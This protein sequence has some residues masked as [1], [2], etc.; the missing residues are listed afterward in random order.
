M[1]VFPEIRF[2]YPWLLLNTIDFAL[3]PALEKENA[4]D[5]LD[6]EFILER[7]ARH[8]AA[9][10]PYEHEVLKGMCDIFG[11][12][13][14]QNII[15]IYVAPLRHAFSDP[16]MISTKHSPDEVVNVIAHELMHRLLT[17]N[18]LYED[19]NLI[20][21]WRGLF[22]EGYDRAALI[23]IPIHAGLKMLF[24]E[25]LNEPDRLARDMERCRRFESY[26]QAWEYVEANDYRQIIAKLRAG[27]AKLQ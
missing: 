14:R 8:E 24:L 3:R 1:I 17:D 20:A 11:L 16:M 23:H 12:E 21:H 5:L 26:N 13:F 27:Y 25:V 15:D 10:Q 7:L 6:R 4:A 22:G 19:E 2:K 18:T 9:W